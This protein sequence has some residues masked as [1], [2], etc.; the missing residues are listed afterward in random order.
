M[1]FSSSK[2]D[3]PIGL[4]DDDFVMRLIL[5]AAAR[6]GTKKLGTQKQMVS[7]NCPLTEKTCAL[8]V[9]WDH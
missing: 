2:E 3:V 6:N 1:G 5:K 7:A 9:V 4:L 8:H